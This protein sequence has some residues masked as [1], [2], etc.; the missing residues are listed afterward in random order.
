M[1]QL[2][3]KAKHSFRKIYIHRTFTY[4]HLRI[5]FNKTMIIINDAAACLYTRIY[6]KMTIYV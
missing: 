3:P 6:L 2:I 4:T 5:E 1:C